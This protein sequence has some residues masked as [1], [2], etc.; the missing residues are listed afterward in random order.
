MEL[1]ET[2]TVSLGKKHAFSLRASS[3]IMLLP[4]IFYFHKNIIFFVDMTRSERMTC[5]LKYG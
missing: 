3:T 5:L 2:N 1:T 4:V